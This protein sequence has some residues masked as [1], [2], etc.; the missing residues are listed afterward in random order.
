MKRPMLTAVTV[1]ALLGAGSASAG[2]GT[3]YPTV[4]AKFKYKL[5]GGKATFKGAIDSPK[6]G[7]V[8]ARKVVLYRQHSGNTGKVGG[9]HTNNNG[10]FEINLGSGPP[11]EGKYY[12]TVKQSKLGE[13]TCLARTSPSV[14]LESG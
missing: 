9:D 13:N 11:R 7:C 8:Q 4:F 3:E 1:V 14:K 6:G 5:E 2:G 10:K 12:A